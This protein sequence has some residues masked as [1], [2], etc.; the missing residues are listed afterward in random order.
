MHLDKKPRHRT[1]WIGLI[2]ATAMAS[3]VGWWVID[4][5]RS[6]NS[7]YEE[8]TAA[9]LNTPN[10]VAKAESG[11]RSAIVPSWEWFHDGQIWEY[12]SKWSPRKSSRE[13]ALVP[14]TVKASSE[15]DMRI[16]VRAKAPLARMFDAAKRDGIDLMLSSAYRSR[17]DQQD[18]YDLYL[19]LKGRSYVDSYVA[20]AGA[21]EHETGMVVDISSDSP[22]CVKDSDACTLQPEAIV[23]LAENAPSYGFIQRYPS[24]KQSTTGVA[25]EAW[26]YR[27]VGVMLAEFLDSENLTF[28]EFVRQVAPGYVNNQ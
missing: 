12:I 24:G 26:H 23:W 13:G 25:G 7:S 21:S 11:D 9:N 8:T 19:V 27:Y 10:I 17:K 6:I 15:G 28:D 5:A 22:D 16:D 20:P 3:Y 4:T 2:L 1:N 14:V 18:L